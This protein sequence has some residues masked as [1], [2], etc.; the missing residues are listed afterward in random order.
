MRKV[1]SGL[2]C[3]LLV[4]TFLLSC[5]DVEK[6]TEERPE[7]AAAISKVLRERWQKGYMTEDV[8]LYMSAYWPD[9][10]LYSSDNGTDSDTS[11]DVIFTDIQ[12]ER[13]SAIKVFRKFQDIE[14]EISEPPQIEIL[15]T[16]RTK[17][18]VRNHYKIQFVIADGT[19]LEG[20]YTGYYAEGDSIFTFELKESSNGEREWRITVWKDE[21]FS[22][23]E[24]NA[25]NNLM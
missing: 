21:A 5:G 6:I 25:A 8:D 15:N 17:A 16:E 4:V 14:I 19:S 22:P 9:G 11:D 20:G 3:I 10:F 7:E 2:Y 23:E 13:D 1:F 24:I 18:E 12:V